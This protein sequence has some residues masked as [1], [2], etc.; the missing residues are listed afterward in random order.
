MHSDGLLRNLDVM[1]EAGMMVT[2]PNEARVRGDVLLLVGRGAARG[3][4]ATARAAAHRAARAGERRRQPSAAFV[5][6]CPGRGEAKALDG[7]DIKTIGRA[8]RRSAGP[9]RR[10]CGRALPGRPVNGSASPGA[11]ARCPGGRP[12]RRAVRRRGLVGRASRRA[13]DR[14][15]VRPGR[16]SQCRRRVSPACRWRPPTTRPACCR[17]AAG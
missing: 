11:R 1:R 16:R 15:A 8:R 9:A 10:R 14:D 6:L 17:R 3:V 13:D 5:W 7:V 12:A 2:T 4:A